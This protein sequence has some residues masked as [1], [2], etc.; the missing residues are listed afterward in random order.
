MRNKKIIIPSAIVA[1]VAIGIGIYFFVF[2]NDETPATAQST[3]QVQPETANVQPEPP[4]PAPAPAPTPTPPSVPQGFSKQQYSTS[5]PTSIWVVVNKKRPL[6]Q[7]YIPGDLTSVAGGQ[8]RTEAAGALQTLLTASKQAGVPMQIISSYRSYAT[9]SSTY[10]NYVAQDGVAQADTYSARPGH[11]EHQ[12]G[13]AVDL[14]NGTCNLE[15]CFGDTAAGK[16]LASNAYQYGFIVRYKNGA[17]PITGYQY[18]PWHIRYVGK[19]LAA[20]L[21]KSGQTMEEFFGLGSAPSY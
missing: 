9:Q 7:S 19:S 4:T 5:D 3:Q 18:E 12:S 21:Q 11:S 2:K 8:M 15:I 10:N 20:E 6:P 14:G 17:T 13:L 16:W 1:T